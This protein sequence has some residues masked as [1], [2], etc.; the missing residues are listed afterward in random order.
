MDNSIYTLDVFLNM[1][2]FHHFA[3]F[4]LSRNTN[5]KSHQTLGKE[6]SDNRVVTKLPFIKEPGKS[7]LF[8]M[9]ILMWVLT[10]YPIPV[11]LVIFLL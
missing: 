3:Q 11:S 9:E 10:G 8:L 6:Q 2:C 7:T 5:D 4:G 1:P